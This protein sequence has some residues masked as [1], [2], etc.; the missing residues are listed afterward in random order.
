LAVFECRTLT[1]R[2]PDQITLKYTLS[3]DYFDQQVSQNIPSDFTSG[4]AACDLQESEAV[5]NSDG[6][7]GAFS[8]FVT[9]L[10]DCGSQEATNSATS[11]LFTKTIDR[12]LAPARPFLCPPLQNNAIIQT[13]PFVCCGEA[14]TK[15]PQ[16][17]S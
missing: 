6:T 12:P 10:S 4:L 1:A 7:L 8:P 13:L 14:A 2:T 11:A 9:I 17:K 5:Y 3:D 16:S 15:F